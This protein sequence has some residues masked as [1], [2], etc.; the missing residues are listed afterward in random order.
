MNHLCFMPL[1]EAV[2]AFYLLGPLCILNS[3]SSVT[4]ETITSRRLTLALAT[5][6]QPSRSG[7]LS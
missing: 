3:Y 4:N 1:P 5:K 6:V 2:N 7:S